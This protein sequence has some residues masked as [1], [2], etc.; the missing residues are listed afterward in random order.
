MNSKCHFVNIKEFNGQKLDILHLCD[1]V[2][3]SASLSLSWARP[4]LSKVT[5]WPKE[6]INIEM[7]RKLQNEASR[8]K[9]SKYLMLRSYL[10]QWQ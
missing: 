9:K 5:A 2:K 6:K 7:S 1:F 3:A 10:Y 4:K 8:R